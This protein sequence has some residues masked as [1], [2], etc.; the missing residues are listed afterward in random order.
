MNL[1]NSSRRLFYG[2]VL[3]TILSLL[4]YVM[5]FQGKYLRL[6]AEKLANKRL[7]IDLIVAYNV[8]RQKRQICQPGLEF[9]SCF[10]VANQLS[11]EFAT[12]GATNP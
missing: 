8:F 12:R 7:W 11:V 10:Q 2:L 9:Q 4:L 5:N 6:P 1:L 3:V